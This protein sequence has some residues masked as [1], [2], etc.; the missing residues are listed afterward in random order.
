MLQECMHNKTEHSMVQQVGFTVKRNISRAAVELGKEGECSLGAR[1][2]DA[3]HGK[4]QLC[5]HVHLLSILLAVGLQPM[6]LM[7]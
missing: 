3:R 4:A 7:P 6:S 2:R 5:R 1:G